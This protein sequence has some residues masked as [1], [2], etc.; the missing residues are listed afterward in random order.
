VPGPDSKSVTYTEIQSQNGLQDKKSEPG[1]RGNRI[2][3]AVTVFFCF[4]IDT[5]ETCRI[6]RR[7]RD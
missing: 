5:F 6:S 7:L 4:E 1:F 3:C 2:G